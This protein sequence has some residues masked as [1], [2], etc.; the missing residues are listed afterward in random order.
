MLIALLIERSVQ[1]SAEKYMKSKE[2]QEK[3]A[4]IIFLTARYDWI[5]SGSEGIIFVKLQGF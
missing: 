5:S 3:S 1:V 2:N 4:K